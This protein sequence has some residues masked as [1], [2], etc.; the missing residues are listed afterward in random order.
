[1]KFFQ[2]KLRSV[3][4]TLIELLVVISIISILL[5]ILMVNFQSARESAKNKA[6]QASVSEAQ[7]AIELYK[8]QNGVYP[9]ALTDI[10]PEYVADLP[11]STDSANSACA[12]QYQSDG[13]SFKLT[14]YRCYLAPAPANGIQ[15]DSE[16][17]RCPSGCSTCASVTF[18]DSYKSSTDFYESLAVYSL[19]GQCL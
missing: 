2:S 10:V 4:F 16:Y 9:A 1:M 7:L 6:I 8:S 13:S 18:N 5:T 14:A 3:G 15:P 19:G 12:I 17:A 11:S